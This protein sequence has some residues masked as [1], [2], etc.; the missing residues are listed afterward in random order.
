MA[1]SPYEPPSEIMQI[2]KAKLGEGYSF[3]KERERLDK[4]ISRARRTVRKLLLM[5]LNREEWTEKSDR[6]EENPRFVRKFADL[7]P[8]VER[9]TSFTLSVQERLLLPDNLASPESFLKKGEKESSSAPQIIQVGAPQGEEK[10]GGF[11]ESVRG[12]FSGIHDVRIRRMELEQERWLREHREPSIGTEKPTQPQENL[13]DRLKD[14]NAALIGVWKFY[15]AVPG[16][17]DYHTR[18]D[19]P[20]LENCHEDLKQR[21]GALLADLD[22]FAGAVHHLDL[23]EIGAREDNFVK[24]LTRIVGEAMSRPIFYEGGGINPIGRSGEY[25]RRGR[26]EE[27]Y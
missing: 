15:V 27:R 13:L 17:H 11:R 8:L 4:D 25:G 5:T 22:A 2:I 9:M 10:K 3:A 18:L 26:D 14:V 1:V 6:V 21:F 19:D 16:L 20:Y 7:F 23:K 24:A 12:F